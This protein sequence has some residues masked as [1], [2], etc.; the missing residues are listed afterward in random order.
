[1]PLREPPSGAWGAPT[2]ETVHEVEDAVFDGGLAVIGCGAG[3]EFEAGGFAGLED[4][5]A[6]QTGSSAGC[7]CFIS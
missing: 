5:I 7:G 3:A 2:G 6:G 4:V 1:M